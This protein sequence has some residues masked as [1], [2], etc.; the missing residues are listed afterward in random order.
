MHRRH[1]LALFLAVPAAALAQRIPLEAGPIKRLK[2][3][4]HLWPPRIAPEGPVTMIVNLATQRAYV[5]R[6]GV[7]ISVSTGSKGHEMPTGLFTILQNQVDHHSNLYA[8][9]P[10]RSCSG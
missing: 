4:E 2:P 8:N 10:F 5:Y 6:N 9:A 1:V 7:P 3:G